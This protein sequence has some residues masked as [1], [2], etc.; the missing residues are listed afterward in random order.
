MIDRAVNMIKGGCYHFP[1]GDL[2]SNIDRNY[3][4]L[5]VVVNIAAIF[6]AAYRLLWK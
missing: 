4:M 5:A 2:G 1:T 6:V 3:V